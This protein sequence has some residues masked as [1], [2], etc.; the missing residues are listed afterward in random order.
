MEGHTHTAEANTY[1]LVVALEDAVGDDVERALEDEGGRKDAHHIGG[2]LLAHQVVDEAHFV[3]RIQT[4][5][6][7]SVG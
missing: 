7:K 1:A 4:I 6:R 3:R 5:A 2:R